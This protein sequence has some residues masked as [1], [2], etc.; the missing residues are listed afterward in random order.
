MSGLDIFA[1]IVLI[2]L[3]ITLIAGFIALA[4]LPGKIATQRDHPQ[5]EAITVAGWFG[6]L[7][8]G[9][10]WPLALIWAFSR[11][12]LLAGATV[13]P[14]PNSGEGVSS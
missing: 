1:W 7:T 5:R 13:D 10:F 9:V 4:M 12:P 3:A 2:V 14:K 6:A 11:P 8:G